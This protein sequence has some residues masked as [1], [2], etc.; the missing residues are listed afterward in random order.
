[1]KPI[2]IF[3]H[4]DCEPPGYYTRLLKELGLAYRQTCLL[5]GKSSD[6]NPANYSGLVFM[7]GPGNV[8]QPDDW[9]ILEIAIIH[10]ALKQ[11]V[12]VLGICL[13]A[14]MLCLAMGGKVRQGDSVE[15]GWHNVE[16]TRQGLENPLFSRVPMQFS[17]FHWHAHHC[18]PPEGIP[19]LARSDCTECQAFAFGKHLALQFHLEMDA[20]TIKTLISLYA[21][22]LTGDSPCVQNKQQ[23][24]ENIEQ[25][26]QQNFE[27]ADILVAG[28]F[29]SLK[30]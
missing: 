30:G 23:I 19:V 12:P 1:M 16:L 26:C 14:Q 10:K 27:L 3:T 8:N 21:S 24:L 11:N 29:N 9:M 18:I 7:G 28:W 25:R 15:V 22:D 20:E 4:A 6:I 13:G 5:V 2:L 17:T